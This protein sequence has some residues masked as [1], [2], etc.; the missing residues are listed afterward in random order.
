MSEAPQALSDI[1]QLLTGLHGGEVER[2]QALALLRRHRPQSV[3]I[4][5][6]TLLSFGRCRLGRL[7]VQLL[8][9]RF[10]FWLQLLAHCRLHLAIGLIGRLDRITQR[11]EL[12]DWVRHAR[13]QLLHCQQFTLLRI[14]DRAQ[15]LHPHL[16]N[17]GEQRLHHCR[18]L[19]RHVLGC[20]H[21]PRERITHQVHRLIAAT[22]GWMPSTDTRMPPFFST[23]ESHST[24]SLASLA[25]RR[26]V[27]SASNSYHISRRAIL[28]PSFSNRASNSR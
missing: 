1:I 26:S 23:S 17:W 14:G 6:R 3:V 28:T 5:H 2:G 11:V 25:A 16:H 24:S 18:I 8:A 21:A 19:R 15:H 12:A 4:Q 7:A 27:Q 20:Q 13:P 10:E 22:P 9:H